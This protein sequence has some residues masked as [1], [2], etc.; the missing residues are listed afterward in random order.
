[1]GRRVAFL[2][3]GVCVLAALAG[4]APR[5]AHGQAPAVPPAP[6]RAP[7]ADPFSGH[8]LT[9][10]LQWS[11]VFFRAFPDEVATPVHDVGSTV[12]QANDSGHA[13]PLLQ[14]IS[15]AWEFLTFKDVEGQAVAGVSLL[16]A[17]AT[18]HADSTFSQQGPLS[19]DYWLVAPFLFLRGGPLFGADSD[20]YFRGG[21]GY[22][23]ATLRAQAGYYSQVNLRGQ[24]YR[25]GG[26]AWDAAS[27]FLWE[28]HWRHWVLSRR[29][30]LIALPTG[31]DRFVFQDFSLAL[32]YRW[33][34]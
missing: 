3:W 6:P 30:T 32:G 23:A 26:M 8:E 29:S 34:L 22:G 21:W 12:Y 13:Q 15:P 14:Y 31:R 10:A 4:G 17:A 2:L 7:A 28:L 33:N 19:G 27:I 11:T 18:F 25:R 1:M 20:I 24:Q 5:S 9:V 16:S